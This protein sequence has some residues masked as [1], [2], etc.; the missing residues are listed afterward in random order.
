MTA[1]KEL[2]SLNLYMET[3]VFLLIENLGPDYKWFGTSAT[4]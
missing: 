4:T 3:L 1:S 2:F